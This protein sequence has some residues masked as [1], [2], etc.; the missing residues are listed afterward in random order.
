MLNVTTLSEVLSATVDKAT[1]TMEHTV[2]VSV[3]IECMQES[4]IVELVVLQILMSV[5]KR[6]TIAT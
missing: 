6:V 2:K 4:T 3:Y 5:L 1:D